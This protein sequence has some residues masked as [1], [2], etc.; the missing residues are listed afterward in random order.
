MLRNELIV[1]NLKKV[2]WKMDEKNNF[3]KTL[4]FY[5]FESSFEKMKSY[6]MKNE[7]LGIDFEEYKNRC[8]ESLEFLER[9][10]KELNKE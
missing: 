8:L 1:E 9:K 3:G 6:L 7:K 5:V 4:P 2:R 10:H